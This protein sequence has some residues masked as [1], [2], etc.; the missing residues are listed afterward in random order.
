MM[1][2]DVRLWIFLLQMSTRSSIPKFFVAPTTL[3]LFAFVSLGPATTWCFHRPAKFLPHILA[4]GS[5]IETPV[6]IRPWPP[7]FRSLNHIVHSFIHP[8]HENDLQ[9]YL[10]HRI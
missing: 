6:L 8:G 9:R 5:S 1:N 7:T 10:L 2:E 4:T 3:V